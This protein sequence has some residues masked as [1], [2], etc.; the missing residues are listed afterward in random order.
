MPV[1][2]VTPI[3]VLSDGSFAVSTTFLAVAGPLSN[4]NTI[5]CG[6]VADGRAAR[7]IDLGAQAHVGGV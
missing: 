5:D 4:T 2:W 1:D 6:Q 7:R 3:N